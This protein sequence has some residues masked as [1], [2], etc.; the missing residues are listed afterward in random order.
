M[1]AEYVVLSTACIDLIQMVVLWCEL[2]WSL[3]ISDDFGDL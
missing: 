2:S 1:K 3:G